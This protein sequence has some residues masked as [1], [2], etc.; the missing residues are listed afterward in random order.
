[1]TLRRWT[2]AVTLALP[3]APLLAEEPAP[4]ADPLAGFGW[5][6]DLAGSCWTAALPG[7]TLRDTQCYEVRF[8]RFL[9]GSI[10]L[11]PVASP[12]ETAATAPKLPHGAGFGGENVCKA[13]EGGRI[14]CWNWGSDG[15]FA[16]GEFLAD[17]E[18]FRYPLSRKPGSTAPEQRMTWKRLDADSIRVSREEKDGEAWNES[19]AVVYTR[20]RP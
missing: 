5:L 15:T 16:P 12:G 14:A 8:G 9:S 2:L 20:V 6:R 3:A 4:K 7:G 11:E 1:M 19:F 13:E 10:R 18:L 17:G